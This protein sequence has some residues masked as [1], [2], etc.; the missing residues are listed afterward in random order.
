MMIDRPLEEFMPT[1]ITTVFKLRENEVGKMEAICQDISK[2]DPRFKFEIVRFSTGSGLLKL[3]NKDEENAASRAMW[4][5]DRF[6]EHFN[7]RPNYEIRRHWVQE[8][9]R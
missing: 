6:L 9:K 4:I 3:F 7:R 2:K 5:K 1:R 8:V